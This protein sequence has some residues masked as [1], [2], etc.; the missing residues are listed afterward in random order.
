[1]LLKLN[2]FLYLGLLNEFLEHLT[3]S[4]GLHCRLGAELL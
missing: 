4:L 3:D 2:E 1:M